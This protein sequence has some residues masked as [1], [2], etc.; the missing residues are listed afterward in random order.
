[1]VA[2]FVHRLGQCRATCQL[3]KLKSTSHL[4]SFVKDD[5]RILNVPMP[6]VEPCKACPERVQLANGLCR[7]HD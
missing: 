6:F 1:M 7:T 5:A 2:I 3:A 4:G